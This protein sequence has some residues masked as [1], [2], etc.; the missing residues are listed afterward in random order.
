MFRYADFVQLLGG[1]E[2]QLGL[3]VGIGMVGAICSRVLQGVAIDRYGARLVWLT[4][5]VLLILSILSHLTID[6]LD[7]PAVF[8]ARVALMSSL[9][10]VF[11]SSITYIS[12]RAP[13]QRVPEMIGMLG[14]SGFIGWGVGPPL[15]DWLFGMGPVTRVHTDHM[16]LVA[17]CLIGL[18]LLFATL[19]TRGATRRVRQRRQPPL[20]W[21][22]RRYHPGPILLVSAAMGIGISLPTIFLRPYTV[23]LAIPRIQTFFIVYAVTAFS[24]RVATRRFPEQV[25]IRRMILMGLAS[26]TVSMLLYLVVASEAALCLPAIAAG[27]AHAFLFPAVIGGGSQAFP[28]RYRGLGTTL[29]LGL[30]DVGGLVGQPALGGLV[31]LSR[32]IGMPAYPTMFIT[33]AIFFAA[34]AIYFGLVTREPKN[35]SEAAD[36]I[37]DKTFRQSDSAIVDEV[38]I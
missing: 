37:S 7:T 25:G 38:S 22:V 18:S 12:L 3:I 23:E 35:C 5:L 28:D 34:V 2:G 27:V 19:A 20:V 33:A 36:A 11:G 17:A 13:P 6:R 31:E 30:F 10:G 4:S 26:M 21:L 1:S 29:M 24:V 8:L 9:A 14:T 16:F 15:A 32:T